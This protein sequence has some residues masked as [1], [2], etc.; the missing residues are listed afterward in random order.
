MDQ[1]L[2]FFAWRRSS[3]YG[4]VA[5]STLTASGRLTGS[6]ALT[7]TNTEQAGD[8][9]TEPL[10]FDLLG[11]GDAAA[12]KPGAVRRMVPPPGATD[13]ENTKCAY[14]ELAAPDLPWRYTP[15]LAAGRR[16]APWIVLVVG[17][18]TEIAIQPGGTVT[19]APSALQAH[20]LAL[21]PRWAHVQDDPDHPGQQ[22]VARLLSPRPLGDADSPPT[23]WT[24]VVVPAFTP[25]GGPAWDGS[26]AVTL[27]LYHAWEFGTGP[28]GDFPSL[29]ARLKP[30]DPAATPGRAALDYTPLP[31]AGGGLVVRGALAPI[32][33]TDDDVPVEVADDIRT[34]TSPLVDPRRPVVTLPAYGDAWVADASSTTWGGAFHVD[35]RHR[36]VAGLGLE[37]GIDEQDK[38]SDAA[39]AQAGALDE[40]SLRVRNLTA[41]LAAAAALWNRRLPADPIRRL[42]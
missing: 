12:L 5:S 40:A 29:A 11:P 25:S 8:T 2:D 23:A 37:A 36:T 34:L 30:G 7:L 14:V 19:I 6:V 1:R 22:L 41:G 4:A 35:P 39:A 31:D 21:S 24:A 15:Q 28:A 13:A 10:R 42:A 16:L 9:A 20:D 26:T 3:V 18:P 17:T 33:S 27:P 38:L 32:G